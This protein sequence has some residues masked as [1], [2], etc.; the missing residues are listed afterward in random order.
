MMRKGKHSA[1]EILVTGGAGFIGSHLVDELLKRGH[2]VTVLDNLRNGSLDRLASASTNPQFVFIKGDILQKSVCLEGCAG[3]DVVYHLACLGVRHSLHSPLENHKVNAEGTLRVLEAARQKKV[4][5]FFYISTSEV[6]GGIR[7]F[8]ITEESLTLP[9]TIYGASKLAGEHY[10]N[11][12]HKCF[13]MDTTVLRIFNNYGPRAHYEDDAGELIPRVIVSIL[14][15]RQPV[16]CGDGSHTRD[17]FYVKDTAR[18]LSDLLGLNGLNGMTFNIG[19]GVEQSIRDTLEKILAVMGR[20][21]LGI[22]YIEDRPGDV[23]RLWVD[24]KRFFTIADFK[25]QYSF[26]SGL[27]ETIAYY[28]DLFKRKKLTLDVKV[29]NW[30]K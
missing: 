30:E 3:K 25:A 29:R 8:P 12:Y 24:A 11:A 15:N 6:Y 27:S 21:N 28:R 16:I 18:A 9:F 10:T 20:K 2:T 1:L 14:Y 22:R 26:E 5:K 23:H 19:A 7:T 17:F 13:N 4:N